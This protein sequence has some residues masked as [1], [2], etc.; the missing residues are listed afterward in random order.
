L[1]SGNSLSVNTNINN[2]GTL[3]SASNTGVLVLN[4]NSTTTPQN[5]SIA[6]SIC[7]YSVGGL[8]INNTFATSPTVTLNTPVTVAGALT[9]TSGVLN[10]TSTNSLTMQS[11]STAP[12]LTSA[13]TSYVNGPM[14]YQLASTTGTTLNFPIGA[15]ADCRPVALTLLHST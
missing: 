5:Q 7:T 1:G 15:S 10:T 4:S 6:G 8:T 9:L 11:G 3:T 14:T 2:C 13:A 12:V